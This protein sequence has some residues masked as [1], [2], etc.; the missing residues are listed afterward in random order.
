M[1]SRQRAFR[2]LRGSQQHRGGKPVSGLIGRHSCCQTESRIEKHQKYFEL[3]L[4][5]ANFRVERLRLPLQCNSTYAARANL[6]RFGRFVTH[7][8]TSRVRSSTAVR[9]LDTSTATAK[10]NRSTV[11]LGPICCACARADSATSR[12]RTT[13]AILDVNRSRGS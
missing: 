13:S 11:R 5:Y 12:A 2:R 10:T 6:V 3:L 1:G 9:T 8:A 7:L 4:I